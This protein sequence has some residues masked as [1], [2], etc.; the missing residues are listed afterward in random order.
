MAVEA[1]LQGRDGLWFGWSG[2]VSDA[3]PPPATIDCGHMKYVLTDVRPQ[4]FQEYYN[5][6]ANRVLWPILHYRL[7]AL[8]VT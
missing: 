1:T 8:A 5:G 3:P 6:L 7:D 2:Q 4:D